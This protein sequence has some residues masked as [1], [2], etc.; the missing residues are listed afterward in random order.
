MYWHMPTADPEKDARRKERTQNMLDRILDSMKGGKKTFRD[1]YMTVKLSMHL[2]H[3]Q[4]AAEI[5]D[6]ALNEFDELSDRDKMLNSEYLL[7][8]AHV[9]IMLYEKADEKDR[10]PYLGRVAQFAAM[11]HGLFGDCADNCF[12]SHLLFAETRPKTALN[13]VEKYLTC[14]E[15]EIERPLWLCQTFRYYDEMILRRNIL[16]AVMS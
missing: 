4:M 8:S 16:K 7:A 10:G 11:H 13:F 3:L 6:A 5:A 12:Y 1:L 2:G 14:V 15:Q 9:N